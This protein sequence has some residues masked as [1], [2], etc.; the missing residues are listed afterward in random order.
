MSKLDTY[1]NVHQTLTSEKI[2]VQN[3]VLV[4]ATIE[5]NAEIKRL[6]RQLNAAN[7]VNKG[8]LE[9][10]IKETK[11]NEEQNF[12]KAYAFKISEQADAI[13]EIEDPILKYHFNK[14]ILNGTIDEIETVIDKLDE[15]SDKQS[16]KEILKKVKKISIEVS[17]TSDI[18]N[19][20]QLPKV[21]NL[22][23][24]YK[25]L[26]ASIPTKPKFKTKGRDIKKN[27][28]F[29]WIVLYS[30]GTIASLV[31][32]FNDYQIIGGI[33]TFIF[34]MSVIFNLMK[35]SL[36]NKFKTDTNNYYNKL[37]PEYEMKNSEIINL[38]ENHKI[39]SF[40]D[41]ISKEFKDYSYYAKEFEK[42]ETKFQ[43]KWSN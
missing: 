43:N 16:A 26:E 4:K 25:S 33:M 28:I 14:I 30:M 2:Q 22:L 8:I 36:A 9:N 17:Q 29:L 13:L 24:D 3:Q 38:L 11:H 35:I 34:T 7:A 41:G 23:I 19:S 27:K 5:N 12:Y 6:Q 32:A 15:I 42:I 21:I 37:I 1:L 31:L 20:S 39:H 40:I 10:Q 18:Y